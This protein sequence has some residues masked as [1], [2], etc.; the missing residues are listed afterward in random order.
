M[1]AANGFIF[2]LLYVDWYENV[3][4][5]DGC[6]LLWK[7]KDYRLVHPRFI[8]PE[9]G[10][11]AF[12]SIFCSGLRKVASSISLVFTGAAWSSQPLHILRNAG[13]L[14]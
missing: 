9:N 6:M 12:P 11:A 13:K 7:N 4:A 10:L 3:K 5:N 1:D 14:G 8:D 2:P